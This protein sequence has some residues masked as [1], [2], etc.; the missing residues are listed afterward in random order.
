[1]TQFFQQKCFHSMHHSIWCFPKWGAI[2]FAVPFLNDLRYRFLVCNNQSE[3]QR[4]FRVS[5]TG[6]FFWVVWLRIA[7][8]AR[9]MKPE[10][11]ASQYL[12]ALCLMF[13]RMYLLRIRSFIF[14]VKSNYFYH[15]QVSHTCSRQSNLPFEKSVHVG[16]AARSRVGELPLFSNKKFVFFLSD[17]W[18][19]SP[20]I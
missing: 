15:A 4:G 7:T 9:R 3:I 5:P 18:E 8:V 16:L 2:F 10:D 6:W 20:C 1:M 11:C 12:K 17:N 14:P 13:T 19:K